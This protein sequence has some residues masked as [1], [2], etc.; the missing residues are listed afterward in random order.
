LRPRPGAPPPPSNAARST[1]AS[2]PD[3]NKPPW[4]RRAV[5]LGVVAEIIQPAHTRQRIAK[6][7]ADARCL[8]EVAGTSGA[9]PRANV[10]RTRAG[11]ARQPGVPSARN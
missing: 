9:V 7:L 5:G 6:I 2:S 11:W 1:P 10:V 8:P 4:H 3:T